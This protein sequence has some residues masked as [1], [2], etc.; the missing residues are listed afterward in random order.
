MI[1][2]GRVCGWGG[3][4]GVSDTNYLY[5]VRW[6]WINIWFFYPK[7][8]LLWQGLF[9]MESTTP[10]P[11]LILNTIDIISSRWVPEIFWIQFLFFIYLF[12]RMQRYKLQL[13][14]MFHKMCYVSKPNLQFTSNGMSIFLFL[15]ENCL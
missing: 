13:I 3:V 12:V 9:Y 4:G 2:L 5:P 10:P 15:F 6:G 11:Q 7:V 1:Q 14:R 8:M